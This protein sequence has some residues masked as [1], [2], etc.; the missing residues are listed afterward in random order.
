MRTTLLKKLLSLSLA[1]TLLLGC[2]SYALAWE[3]QWAHDEDLSDYRLCENFGDITLK[4]AVTDHA[5]ISTWEE[6]AFV[7][8]LEEVTNVD[9]T[10]EL[11]PYEGRAEKLGLIL[12][13]G[14]YPDV[15]LSCG[16]TSAM[17]S[18]FGVDEKMFLPLNDLI[19]EHGTFTKKMFAEFPGTEGLISQLDGNI[20]SLPVVNECFHCTAPRK[21][22]INQAWLDNLG[23]KMPTTLD[24][25][26]EVLVAFR[27]QDANGNGDPND[28]IPFGGDTNN[29]NLG[30][31]AGWFGIEAVDN[32]GY[33]FFAKK[34]GKLFFSANKPEFKEF[35]EY[36]ADLYKENLIDPELFT[37]DLENWKAKGG[38]DLYGVCIGYGPGDWYTNYEKGTADYEKYGENAFTCL[39]V[40]KGCDNPLFHRNSNGVT[41]FRTQLAITDKCDEEKLLA[42]LR[43]LDVLYMEENSVQ[44]GN[45]LLGVEYEKIGDHLYREI[46]HK[47]G[48]NGWTQEDEDRNTWARCFTQSMPRNM[49]VAK[50]LPYD[51]DEPDPSFMDLCDEVYRPYMTETFKAVWGANQEDAE[52]KSIIETDL[53]SYIK[54]KIAQWV[55]GEADVNAE[56]DAYCQQ[57]EAY[58]LSELTDIYAREQ[59]LD[60]HEAN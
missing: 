15:F 1:L 23:L 11:I 43:W 7:K 22:W 27:D 26:Y 46:Y 45:G 48:E 20:Y 17:I 42:I 40:L 51:K 39:P 4:V 16:M 60:I 35:I 41:L 21:F 14:N 53:K 52:R 54:S 9:L 6:N 5:T 33:P 3:P 50:L 24:E 37:Q 30:M 56:W 57:L 49:G 38:K 44:A 34:D 19:E 29:L 59:G 10:F 32:N 25:L 36:F 31:C 12:N 28:E 13:S 58:G 2:A 47:V 55:S 18:R 8:W